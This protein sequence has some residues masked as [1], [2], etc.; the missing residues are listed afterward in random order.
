IQEWEDRKPVEYE[1]RI[2]IG[3]EAGRRAAQEG[4]IYAA[5]FLRLQKD[6][7]FVVYVEGLNGIGPQGDFMALGG[8]GRAARLER[9][10]ATAPDLGD[11]PRSLMKHGRFKLYLTTPALFSRGWLPSW[12]TPPTFTGLR[13]GLRLRLVAAAVG[14]PIPLSGFDM[15]LSQPKPMRRAVPA[16]SVY[17]FE[18]EDGDPQLAYRAFYFQSISELSHEA[19]FGITLVGG[20]DYV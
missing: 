19:G 18:L 12:L 20:W 3:L 16:G 13:N 7:G 15:A 11:P 14:R 17:F 4:R 10:E 5:Q 2:G 6:H 9:L 8:E 1:E